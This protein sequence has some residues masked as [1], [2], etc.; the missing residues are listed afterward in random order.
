MTRRALLVNIIGLTLFRTKVL[1]SESFNNSNFKYI[2]TNKKLKD[3][4][5]NFYINVFNLFPPMK[6]H[7]IIET[8]SN[9]LL[10]DK[11]IY[12]LVQSKLKDI[13]N[14]FSIVTYKL[15]ALKKQKKEMLNQT[16]QLLKNK[17]AINGY[18]EI[19]SSGRY[20]DY[21]EE[22]LKIVGKRYYSSEENPSYSIED[23][24]DR[25]QINIGAEF[26]P[27]NNY[28]TE[29]S[30]I[31][32]NSLDLVTIYIGLH[33]CPINLREKYIHSIAKLIKKD[34]QLILR[35]HDCHNIEQEKIAALAH[36]VFNMGTQET[37]EYNKKELR[38]FYSLKYIKALIVQS[39][40]KF[41]GKTLYQSGDPTKNALMSFTKVKS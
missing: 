38:N 40:F 3:E 22:D 37:W 36:D 30:E 19:G 16:I 25:G 39:G 26:I 32:D 13:T 35:D 31:K 34:G 14:V 5:L 17:K 24:V 10:T 11:E 8:E 29:F 9:K 23:M 15:P 20:L 1:S 18:M 41:D 6:L 27:M 28:K 4:F 2:Y 21:L 7:N 33:H 12:L